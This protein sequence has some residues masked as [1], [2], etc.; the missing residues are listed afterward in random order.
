MAYLKLTNDWTFTVNKKGKFDIENPSE[1]KK[2]RIRKNNG[3]IEFLIGEMDDLP[4][5]I[6][7]RLERYCNLIQNNS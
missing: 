6:Q 1:N 2:V 5:Y 3:T 4:P 7:D